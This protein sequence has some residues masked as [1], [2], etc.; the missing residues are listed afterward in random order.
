MILD[1]NACGGFG[2]GNDLR[3]PGS[4]VRETSRQRPGARRFSPLQLPSVRSHRNFLTL[5]LTRL[6]KRSQ[7]RVPIPFLLRAFSFSLAKPRENSERI[8][9]Q[10]DA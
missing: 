4:I 2:A 7:R 1:G 8:H 10:K 9:Q 5:P 6:L 3:I